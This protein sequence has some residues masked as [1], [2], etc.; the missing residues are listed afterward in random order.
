[1]HRGLPVV[2]SIESVDFN[3]SES[4]FGASII[5]MLAWA[6]EKSSSGSWM[7]SYAPSANDVVS[8]CNVIV[9]ISEVLEYSF[10]SLKSHYPIKL[11]SRKQPFIFYRLGSNLWSKKEHNNFHK[12]TW[13][14][15]FYFNKINHKKVF[16]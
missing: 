2:I 9:G 10:P 8:I 6:S 16:K 1:M 7:S 14:R 11:K 4:K 13:K 3:S 15:G 5:S 12:M